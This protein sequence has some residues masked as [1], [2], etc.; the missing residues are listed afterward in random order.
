[1]IESSTHMLDTTK[2][3]HSGPQHSGQEQPGP[4]RS[5]RRAMARGARGRCPSCGTGKLFR[6]YL[7]VSDTCP[8]CGEEM[9]H[10]RADDA[11]PYFT[12]M[13]VGHIIVPALLVVERTSQPPLW[14]LFAIFL[15]LATI[16]CLL[17]LQPI[18]GALVGL[19]W[20]LGMHGFGGEDDT[21]D[22]WTHS[23]SKQ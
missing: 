18:K 3:Q 19:Q 12:I 20:A 5:K 6:G 9:H 1:M 2:P 23:P 14:L 13:L 15:P 16:M 11:P 22:D 8:A 21:V 7:K 4:R 17:A 10:H